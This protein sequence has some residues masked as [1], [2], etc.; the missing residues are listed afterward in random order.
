[1]RHIAAVKAAQTRMAIARIETIEPAS[2]LISRGYE[3]PLTV[4]GMAA[5]AGFLLSQVN[6]SPARIPGVSSL[7]AG[8][9]AE[10]VGKVAMMAA[11]GWVDG[12]GDETT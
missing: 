3:H 11:S 4:M 7:L 10:V 5:G 12:A 1:M 2:A 9:I 8:G 6:V